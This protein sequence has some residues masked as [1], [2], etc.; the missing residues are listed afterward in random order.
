MPTLELDHFR[1]H[2]GKPF[3]ADCTPSEVEL[4]LIEA[5]SL[6][7]RDLATRAPFVLIFH[8][9]PETLLLPGIYAMRREGFGP[10]QIH[11]G[12]MLPPPGAAPGY[13]YQAV[14]N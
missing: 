7:H 6:T 4:K 8:T 1:P 12:D 14:F 2:V 13:Y 5:S 9:P 10:A 3:I 11:I